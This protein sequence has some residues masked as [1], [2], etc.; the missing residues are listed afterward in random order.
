MAKAD[1]GY[2]S[3]DPKI[4]DEAMSGAST[5]LRI[6]PGSVI[7]LGALCLSVDGKRMHLVS[8]VDAV[9]EWQEGISV[10]T[11]AIEADRNDCLGYVHQAMPLAFAPKAE[12]RDDAL[13]S[14][15]RAFELDPNDMVRC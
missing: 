10:S 4:L 7:A 11:R 12:R 5:A 13:T 3:N 9:A 1:Q 14:A 8:D 15:R 2:R 6:D